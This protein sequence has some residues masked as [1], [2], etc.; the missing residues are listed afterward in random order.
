MS[1]SRILDLKIHTLCLCREMHITAVYFGGSLRN[2]GRSGLVS[3]L[4][5]SLYCISLL[6]LSFSSHQQE[7]LMTDS[8][9]KL[10]NTELMGFFPLCCIGRIKREQKELVSF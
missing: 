10:G 3:G 7:R 6:S 1:M 8:C 5:H 4:A 2:S 9:Q